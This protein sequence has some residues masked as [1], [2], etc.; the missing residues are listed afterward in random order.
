MGHNKKNI[1]IFVKLVII[2]LLNYAAMDRQVALG[3][4][5]SKSTAAP[6]QKT[7]CSLDNKCCFVIS[8]ALAAAGW[9]A[10]VGGISLYR[11]LSKDEDSLPIQDNFHIELKNMGKNSEY[12]AIFYK[13]KLRW[14]S[15]I[16]NKLPGA[17]AAY[18]E[19]WFGG[20]FATGYNGA[21]DDI[22]I[23]YAVEPLDGAGNI[24]GHAGPVF[25]QPGYESVVSGVMKFDIDDFENMS[26]ENIEDIVVHEMGHV[27]GIGTLW[28]HKCGINCPTGDFSYTCLKAN[29]KYKE[30]NFPD[31]KLNLESEGGLGTACGH[32]D[33]T[34][35][36]HPTYS[37]LMTGQ[38]EAHKVQIL[39]TVSAAALEDLG[40]YKV[41]YAAADP[42]PT[43]SLRG[44]GLEMQA[45][46]TNTFNLHGRVKRPEML[47]LN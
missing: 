17:P 37:E 35:F 25:I 24:L 46:P 45:S 5:Q 23:G 14:E 1:S 29:E 8:A 20:E 2:A 13:A 30:F 41:N 42:L 43:N 31:R 18:T 16:T 27:L 32:W 40:G 47:Q 3:A 22:L 33:D 12:D 21:V 9:G 44:S 38:F 26:S 4:N 28:S 15:I 36:S 10:V 11:L 6:A 7:I 34:S 19:D 39:S